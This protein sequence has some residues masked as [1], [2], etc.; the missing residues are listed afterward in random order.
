MDHGVFMFTVTSRSPVAS[1]LSTGSIAVAT[2]PCTVRTSR[3]L[4]TASPSSCSPSWKV[5]PGRTLRTQVMNSLSG[6]GSNDSSR[7]GWS[8]PSFATTTSGSKKAL[9]TT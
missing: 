8:V 2:R 1:T 9:A 5:I 4:A 7:Y 3:F 6:G